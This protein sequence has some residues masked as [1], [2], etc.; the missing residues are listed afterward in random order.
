MVNGMGK[1]MN[2]AVSASTGS[3]TTAVAA[4][5]SDRYFI[6]FEINQDYMSLANSRIAAT[7]PD[8]F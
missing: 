2:K 1:D 7:H 8:L 6:G 3:G 4:L 5:K